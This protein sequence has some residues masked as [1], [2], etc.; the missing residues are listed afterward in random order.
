MSKENKY[1]DSPFGQSVPVR[2]GHVIETSE[3]LV[4]INVVDEPG[5]FGDAPSWNCWVE[6]CEM[7]DGT[8]IQDGKKVKC[9]HDCHRE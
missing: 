8:A 4:A 1:L 5:V 3:G 7:C 2:E 6:F 9:T